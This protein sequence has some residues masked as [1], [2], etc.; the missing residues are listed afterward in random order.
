ME[1]DPFPP[2]AV[3]EEGANFVQVL[4]V[5]ELATDVMD[6]LAAA[7]VVVVVIAV[8]VIAVMAVEVA[9]E[10]AVEAVVVIVE[11]RRPSAQVVLL[12][13][14]GWQHFLYHDLLYHHGLLYHGLSLGLMLSHTLLLLLLFR[15]VLVLFC[16]EAGVARCD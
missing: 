2:V 14:F 9:V 7:A 12:Q 11:D 4:L 6:F 16:A 13:T 5:A 3:G 10:V 15:V 8:V 1:V